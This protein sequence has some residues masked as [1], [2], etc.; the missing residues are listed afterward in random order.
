MLFPVQMYVFHYYFDTQLYLNPYLRFVPHKVGFG[1][2]PTLPS[3]S[4]YEL[5]LMFGLTDIVT[6]E[7]R[8]TLL[9]GLKH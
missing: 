9:W 1:I 2:L 8:G 3:A 6:Q 4:L 7:P 5:C